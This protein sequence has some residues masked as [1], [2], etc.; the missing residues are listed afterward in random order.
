MART[1]NISS[2]ERKEVKASNS[3]APLPAGWYNVA[4][5]NAEEK[6]YDGP[7]SKG[8]E[9]A[10]EPYYNLELRVIEGDFNA[11]RLYGIQVPLFTKW[12]PSTKEGPNKGKR[13]PTNFLP[14]FE[15]LADEFGDPEGEFE[16]PDADDLLGKKLTVRV[17]VVADDYKIKQGEKDA[18]RN[19][20]NGFRAYDEDDDPSPSLEDQPASGGKS[21]SKGDEFDL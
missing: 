11:R 10:G 21:A 7:N 15:A 20:V 17:R 6:A 19:E 18:K 8:K 12:G 4:V 14:F 1:L 3:F 13:F 5:F 2:E 9:H 16:V